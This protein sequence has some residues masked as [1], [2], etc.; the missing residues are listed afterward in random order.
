MLNQFVVINKNLITDSI[1]ANQDPAF[2]NETQ[3]ILRVNKDNEDLLK[4]YIKYSEKEIL[5]FDKSILQKSLVNQHDNSNRPFTRLAITEAGWSFLAH[6]FEG[7]TSLVNSIY[8]EDHLGNKENQHYCKFYDINGDELTNQSEIDTS[9]VKSVFT[10]IP[11]IDYEVVSGEI[12]QY[13]RP[14]TN[15]RV[16]TLIGLIDNNGNAISTKPFVRNLNLKFK[17]TNK[18]IMTD[19]RAP[20]LLRKNFKGA[21]F[22]ANQLQIIFYHEPGIKHEFMIELEYYRE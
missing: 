2:L 12:H 22:D 8:C 16:H 4:N 21:P 19:G 20:K 14:T 17:D 15:V 6:F 7:T 18:T 9:C 13:E 11:G 5:N 10:I 1:K 3:R